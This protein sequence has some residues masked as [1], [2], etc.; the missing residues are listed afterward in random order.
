VTFFTRTTDQNDGQTLF[1]RSL[2]GVMETS[3]GREFSR[4]QKDGRFH[5][6]Q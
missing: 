6:C 2:A 1:G 3:V 5:A 4:L